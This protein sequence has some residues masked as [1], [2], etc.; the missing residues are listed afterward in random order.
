[1]HGLGKM[2]ALSPAG[3]PFDSGS[4]CR[5]GARATARHG[6]RPGPAL[7]G[8]AEAVGRAGLSPMIPRGTEPL[9]EPAPLLSLAAGEASMLAEIWLTP[10]APCGMAEAF[11]AT[12]GTA[13]T[14][15]RAQA[16]PCI[17][18]IDADAFRRRR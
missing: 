13:F 1:V 3:Y 4:S 10:A 7:L 14:D 16:R 12:V 2:T 15:G 9:A 18:G 17:N 6:D 8:E 5:V 11:T